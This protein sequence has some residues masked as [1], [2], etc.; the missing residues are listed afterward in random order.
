LVE[1]AWVT[2]IVGVG[3]IAMM[4]LLVAGTASN[5][6]GNQTTTAVNLANN[7]HEIALG[8][9]F[10]DPENKT[11]WTS[12]EATVSAYDNVTDLDGQTFSP[13]LDVRRLP[14]PGTRTGASA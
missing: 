3:A 1:A 12:R 10:A 13:P 4:E 7:V 2:V 5:A 8:M 6:A 14:I 11:A 9:A